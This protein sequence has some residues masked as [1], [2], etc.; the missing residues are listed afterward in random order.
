[1]NPPIIAINIDSVDWTMLVI[2]AAFILVDIIT[3]VVD[4]ALH[5][6]FMST[7]MR[8]GLVHKCGTLAAMLV[9]GLC[10]IAVS[11][12]SVDLGIPFGVID[13]AGVLIIAME[14]GSIWENCC[15]MNPDLAKL[16]FSQIFGVTNSEIENEN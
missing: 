14:L 8:E 15:E 12:T 1:M 10:D 11:S 2:V 16:P 7:K 6:N 3:G 13:V 4:A 5:G 9:C